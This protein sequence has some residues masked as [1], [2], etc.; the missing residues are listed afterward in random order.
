MSQGFYPRFRRPGQVYTHDFIPAGWYPKSPLV[1]EYPGSVPSKISKVAA[2]AHGSY[3][4]GHL[5]AA[6]LLART[7]VEAVAKAKGIT[8]GS[9]VSK[10]D[11]LY[12]QHLVYEH[13]RDAAHEVR[14]VGNDAAHGDLVEDPIDEEEAAAILE[15]MD[16]VLEGVFIAPAKTAAQ[17]A[18]RQARK[19][20]GTAAHPAAT[21]SS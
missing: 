12:N 6:V 1:K 10:I 2:E 15:L 18:A 21:G 7:T 14:F 16:M 19:D 3:S 9:L 20:A 11:E 8:Q 13:V 17:K 5:Q 4:V